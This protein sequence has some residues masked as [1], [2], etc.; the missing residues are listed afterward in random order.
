MVTEE[1]GVLFTSRYLHMSFDIWALEDLVITAFQ[2]LNMSYFMS[3]MIS[4]NKANNIEDSNSKHLSAV[5]YACEAI[6][7]QNS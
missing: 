5:S 7:I 2:S 1:D 6:P 4:F 3:F